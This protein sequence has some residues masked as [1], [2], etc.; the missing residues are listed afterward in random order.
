MQGPFLLR[1]T[2]CLAKHKPIGPEGLMAYCWLQPTIRPAARP[3]NIIAACSYAAASIMLGPVYAAQ[4]ATYRPV[5]ACSSLRPKRHMLL[6]ATTRP[7]C[8]K[9]QGP[10]RHKTAFSGLRPSFCYF[11]CCKALRAWAAEGTKICLLLQQQ[12]HCSAGTY[13]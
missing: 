4:H 10:S 5:A 2:C 6:L 7:A 12:F 13:A 1:P 3:S 11:S 9:Q 8:C